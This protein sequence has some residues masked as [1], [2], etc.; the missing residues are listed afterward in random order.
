MKHYNI[1]I[2][3]RVHGVGFRWSAKH[4][5]KALNI[6]GFVQ[7]EAEGTVYLEAEGEERNLLTFIEWCRR[8]PL[9]AHVER[10]EFEEKTPVG[11]NNFEIK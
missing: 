4:K 10:L 11:Y 5:A 9:F 2:Y 3:G 8:G 7:N 1:K 6:F